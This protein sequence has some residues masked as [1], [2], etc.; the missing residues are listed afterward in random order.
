[1]TFC[2]QGVDNFFILESS[3]SEAGGRKGDIGRRKGGYITETK[4]IHTYKKS[5]FS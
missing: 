1:M 2:F 5:N 4:W 3:K